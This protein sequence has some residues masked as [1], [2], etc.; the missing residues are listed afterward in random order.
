MYGLYAE[1]AVAHRFPALDA[2]TYFGRKSRGADERAVAAETFPQG[3]P[4][5]VPWVEAERI[6]AP[7]ALAQDTLVAGIRAALAGLAATF[8]LAAVSARQS[9]ALLGEELA[10]LGVGSFFQEC[11]AVAG[12][13]AAAIEAYARR[14]GFAAVEAVVVGD[15][16]VEIAAAERVGCRSVSVT[17]GVRGRE[18][19]EHNR[20]ALVVDTITELVSALNDL[21][22][23]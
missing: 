10:Q 19:L 6:E 3:I 1:Y 22:D 11:I 8:P 5:R 12:A 21:A 13:K 14:A 7:D 17:W 2:T 9:G 23:G 16:E 18:F 4:R 15:T 20:A